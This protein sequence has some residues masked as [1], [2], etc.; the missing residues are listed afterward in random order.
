METC[1]QAGFH[2]GKARLDAVV[3]LIKQPKRK[4]CSQGQGRRGC[5]RSPHPL[6]ILQPPGRP[7]VIQSAIPLAGADMDFVAASY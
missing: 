4:Y 2:L 6:D 1:L 7:L 3:S 5:L